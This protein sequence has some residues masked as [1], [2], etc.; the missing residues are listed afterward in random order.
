MQILVLIVGVMF[1]AASFD[2]NHFGKHLLIP[3][4]PVKKD[5]Q[6]NW[7]VFIKTESTNLGT[8]TDASTN[9]LILA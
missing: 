6:W 1:T 3:C 4:F 7:L 9:R 2:K 5:A 8:S